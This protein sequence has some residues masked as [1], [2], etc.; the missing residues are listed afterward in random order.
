MR[1]ELIEGCIADSLT[2]N[3][4]EESDLTDSQRAIVLR[5]LVNALPEV[6]LNG[7]LVDLLRLRGEVTPLGRCEQCG[8]NVTKYTLEI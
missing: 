3:G 5:R 8:D 7:I 4:V 2:V 6:M 1:L